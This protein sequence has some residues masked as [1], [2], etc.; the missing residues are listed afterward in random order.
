MSAPSIVPLVKLTDDLHGIGR[1][2]WEITAQLKGMPFDPRMVS[3]QLYQRGWS[4]ARS[5]DLLLNQKFTTEA[6]IVLRSAIEVAICLANL[7]VRPSHF[8]EDLKSDTAST[9][10]GQ[11]TIWGKVDSELGSAAKNTD[12]FGVR[13]DGRPHKR[14]SLEKM[15]NE[16]GRPHLYDAHRHLS[17]TAAHVTGVSLIMG[18]EFA[19]DGEP[20]PP[21]LEI[22]R[23]NVLEMAMDALQT[24]IEAHASI[25]GADGVLEA[26]A[27]WGRR[28][29]SPPWSEP[30]E[31]NP[32]ADI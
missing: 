10:A 20:F 5:I 18:V 21:L 22:R 25:I 23:Y 4:N 8:I 14:F 31:G 3:A 16:A 19:D 2:L 9:V 28:L 26:H 29:T 6:E 1:K 24:T 11:A 32:T 12:M 15:A 13:L 17:G 27:E 7:K 30:P